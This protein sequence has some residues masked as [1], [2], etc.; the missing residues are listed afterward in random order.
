MK[1]V[2]VVFFCFCGLL[3]FTVTFSWADSSAETAQEKIEQSY[4]L[5]RQDVEVEFEKI[6]IKVQYKE[7]Y[8]VKKELERWIKYSPQKEDKIFINFTAPEM[9]KGLKLLV[10]RKL[11][12]SDLIWLKLPS[13][14]RSRRI[15]GQ[16][17]GNFFAE[18]D[19]TYRDT[20]QLIG[21]NTRNYKYNFL[22]SN[23]AEWVIE[24]LP[25]KSI[26]SIYDKRIFY[27]NKKYIIEKVL[28]Y[29]HGKICKTQLNKDI[30]KESNEC[31][32]SNLVVF[33]NELHNRKS[34]IK[35]LKRKSK[36][37]VNLPTFSQRDLRR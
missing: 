23:D 30:I 13:M 11:S 20:A 5:Y 22:D 31:W 34:T 15:S 1:R 14:H 32:R 10:H 24:A 18:T 33:V 4:K 3:L 21:E 35:V 36:D 7:G 28:Y 6:K 29:R 16:D 27:L 19:L 37:F 26:T 17:E 25:K 9:D 8:S 12:Q 2:G